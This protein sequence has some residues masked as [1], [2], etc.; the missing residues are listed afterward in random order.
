MMTKTINFAVDGLNLFGENG[1]LGYD[2]SLQ[3]YPN[4][5]QVFYRFVIIVLVSNRP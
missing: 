4:N 3:L 1:Y 2:M 5:H